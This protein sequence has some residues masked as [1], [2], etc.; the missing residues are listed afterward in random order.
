MNHEYY[1][2]PSHQNV[3]ANTIKQSRSTNNIT[4]ITD[5]TRIIPYV[6]VDIKTEVL[7]STKSNE[8]VDY[9]VPI[10]TGLGL[11]S[12]ANP[13][14]GVIRVETTDCVRFTVLSKQQ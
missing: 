3:K 2:R 8:I 12:L 11:H 7:N 13:K 14:K 10:I 9:R 5:H 6:S 1:L 4:V